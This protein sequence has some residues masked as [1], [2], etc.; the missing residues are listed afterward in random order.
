[1]EFGM[2]TIPSS[3]PRKSYLFHHLELRKKCGYLRYDQFNA[4]QIQWSQLGQ[5]SFGFLYLHG[6]RNIKSYRHS[7]KWILWCFGHVWRISFRQS[8][9][10]SSLNDDR[11]DDGSLQKDLR[12]CQKING[13]YLKYSGSAAQHDQQE[14]YSLEAT[15]QIC[16]FFYL[17]WSY[18]QSF[19]SHLCHWLHCGK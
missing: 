18:G 12:T 6:Q 15:F 4:G 9:R 11:K 16:R 13:V 10:R 19:K 17:S 1:M 2:S 8:I 3:K 14:K 7:L 5:K